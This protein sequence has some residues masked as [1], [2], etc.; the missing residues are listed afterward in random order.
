DRFL[1][2]RLIAEQSRGGNAEIRENGLRRLEALFA[3]VEGFGLRNAL[4][5][6]WAAW[7]RLATQPEAEIFRQD[8]IASGQRLATRING[9]NRD[10]R[11]MRKELNGRIAERV[12]RANQLAGQIAGLNK[13]IQQT[14]RGRGEA[15]DLRDER[16]GAL[17][18]LSKLIQ[19]NWFESEDKMVKVSIGNGFPLVT[20]RRANSVEASFDNDEIGFFSLRGIDPKGISRDLTPHIQAG[21][22]KEFVVLR[23]KIV[24][25]LIERLDELASELAF[26]INRLHNSGTG[27]NATYD[28]LTSSFALKPDAI[29]QPLPF[30]KDGLLSIHLVGQN[31]AYLET[32]QVELRAGEDTVQ[33]VVNR[34]NATVANPDLLRAAVNSDGSVTIEAQGA[35]DFVLGEDE[36]DFTTIMGFNNFFENL[37]GARDFR[38]N[39]RLVERPNRISTG[40]GLLP[41]E[42]SVALAINQLQ[43]EPTMRGESITFDEF[44]NGMLAELGL[45]INRAQEELR[46]QRL[47]LDQF[48][49]L[50]N[51]IS[52]VNMDEEVADMVQFQRGF[53]AAA[54]FITSVD[55]MTRTVID[56]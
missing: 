29:T 49:K 19:I 27:L 47:I 42:N 22:L 17:K 40:R 16:E 11:Q 24:V 23:D 8:L 10:F 6:F 50:R 1:T 52:S 30:L 15:N 2:K 3:E 28:R 33:D 9:L 18:E 21:E 7:G 20:G 48:Q 44:Y 36:T 14:D 53:E 55:E 31:N 37:Q 4:N 5:E 25:G 26:R 56:M 13:R 12:E 43:F 45:M 41:G 46:N 35:F 39:R 32:Y 51:E 54:K 38:I 34:I